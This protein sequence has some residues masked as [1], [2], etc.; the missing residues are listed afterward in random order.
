MPALK[1]IVVVLG[2]AIVAMA[3]LIAVKIGA[4]APA[5][6]AGREATKPG[7]HTVVLPPGAR[8][9]ETLAVGERVVL[10]VVEASGTQRLLIVDPAKGAQPVATL[11]VECLP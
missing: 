2:V 6:L 11:I 5:T 9:A 1:L 8:L 3:T 7:E 4:R 10:R